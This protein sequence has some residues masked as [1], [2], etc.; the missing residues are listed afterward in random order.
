[1][2]TNGTFGIEK[3]DIVRGKTKVLLCHLR[4]YM[5][6]CRSWPTGGL[7]WLA[8]KPKKF[9]VSQ[10]GGQLSSSTQGD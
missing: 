6:D 5:R 1:M 9:R 7:P 3:D 2:V 10:I 8:W 4:M